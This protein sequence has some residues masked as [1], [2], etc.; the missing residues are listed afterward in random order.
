MNNNKKQICHRFSKQQ[1]AVLVVSLFLLLIMTLTVVASMKSSILEE[2]MA[3]NQRDRTIAFQAAESALRGA[4]FWMGEQTT[5][6]DPTTDGSSTI[7]TLNGPND[8]SGGNWWN[9]HNQAWWQSSGIQ[10]STPLPEVTQSPRYLIEQQQYIK[11]SLNVGKSQDEHGRQ[12][13]RITTQA[14]GGTE[15]A[16]VTLQTSY[17]KRK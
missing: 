14:T 3:G 5:A 4:E 6:P 12:F 8:G 9:Q 1:G 16:S 17:A 11:D 13:Y 7:W 10:Y 2:K 15:N